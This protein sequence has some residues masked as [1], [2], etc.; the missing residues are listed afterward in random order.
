MTRIPVALVGLHPDVL[1]AW[2]DMIDSAARSEWGQAIERADQRPMM[3]IAEAH[4]VGYYAIVDIKN[5]RNWGWLTG[6]QYRRR[7]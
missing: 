5:G 3:K 7:S 4:G 2:R 6:R 1:Q